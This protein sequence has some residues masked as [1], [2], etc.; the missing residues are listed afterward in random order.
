MSSNES[1]STSQDIEG[2]LSEEALA[3]VGQYSRDP[4]VLLRLRCVSKH[5]HSSVDPHVI[6][7]TVIRQTRYRRIENVDTC[8]IIP[9]ESKERLEAAKAELR[10][11]L[12]HLGLPLKWFD[13]GHACVAGGCV[14]RQLLKAIHPDQK[15]VGWDDSD[16]DIWFGKEVE[17][18]VVSWIVSKYK[19][20]FFQAKATSCYLEIEDDRDPGGTPV[21]IMLNFIPYSTGSAPTIAT[22]NLFDTE[23]LHPPNLLRTF[24]LSV[25]QFAYFA[26]NFIGTSLGCY[27][28]V[29]QHMFLLNIS[30]NKEETTA[31]RIRKYE[32]RGFTIRSGPQPTVVGLN[33]LDIPSAFSCMLKDGLPRT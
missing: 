9:K 11:T 17:S 29:Y 31:K 18:E 28:L 8:H 25:C 3:L 30:L 16:I 21:S 32:S 6:V 23:T 19:P 1:S 12:H 24:D 10:S 15:L 4:E 5:V 14:T 13:E 2:I 26:N 33:Y 27:G 22:D 20:L 7:E